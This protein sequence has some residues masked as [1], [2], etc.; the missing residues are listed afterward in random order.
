MTK[1]GK[2]TLWG[3]WSWCR[4][5]FNRTFM[6]LKAGCDKGKTGRYGSFNRTFMELKDAGGAHRQGGGSFNRTFMELKEISN[7]APQT[8]SPVFQS[9]L[10]GI[11][12]E[13]TSATCCAVVVSIAPLWNWKCSRQYLLPLNYPFQSHLYGIERASLYHHAGSTTRF[14]RTFMELKAVKGFAPVPVE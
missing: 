14:N 5:G 2:R 12:R 9:H 6:E 4:A 8:Q 13:Q 1:S 7:F 3:R 10:Y 11:E